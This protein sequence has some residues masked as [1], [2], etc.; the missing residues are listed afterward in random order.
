MRR[1]TKAALHGAQ[2]PLQRADAGC[3]AASL[4]WAVAYVTALC[5]QKASTSARVC[6]CVGLAVIARRLTVHFMRRHWH[7]P[8]RRRF[9]TRRGYLFAALAAGWLLV[10]NVAW[11]IG[12]VFRTATGCGRLALSYRGRRGRGWH[13]RSLSL[14]ARRISLLLDLRGRHPLTR[15]R[16]AAPQFYRCVGGHFRQRQ[17]ARRL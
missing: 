2:I 11:C 1:L 16:R 6:P 4:C 7:V 14:P 5:S 9:G 12:V 17:E 10:L 13:R 3:N 8:R 15:Y